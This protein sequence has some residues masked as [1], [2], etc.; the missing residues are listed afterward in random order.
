VEALTYLGWITALSANDAGDQ[1]A[2]S[3]GLGLL[4]KASVIDPGYA[5]PHCFLAIGSANFLQPPDNDTVRAE[6][7]ACLEAGPPADMRGLVE[8]FLAELDG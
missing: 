7:D 1:A 8:A 2:V 4:R 6:A 3:D 5:D